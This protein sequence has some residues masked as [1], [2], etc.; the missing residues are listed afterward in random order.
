MRQDILGVPLF[1]L[2]GPW[3]PLVQ[4]PG[5]T[6]GTPAEPQFLC[7]PM[8]FFFWPSS[9][10]EKSPCG[11]RKPKD[12]TEKRQSSLLNRESWEEVAGARK[13]GDSVPVLT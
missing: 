7:P 6:W 12:Q 1:L 13:L 5:D 2:L 8:T 3:T 11:L 4:W 9:M 10:L